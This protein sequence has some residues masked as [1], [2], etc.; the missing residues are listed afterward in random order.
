MLAGIFLFYKMNKDNSAINFVVSVLTRIPT[1]AAEKTSNPEE[2]RKSPSEKKEND[3]SALILGV[4]E[5]L[6]SPF[7]A[8]HFCGPETR[9]R[10]RGATFAIALFFSFFG[11]TENNNMS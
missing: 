5:S 11:D 3:K 6:I 2:Q 9:R 1:V 4:S 10:A 8:T 7:E